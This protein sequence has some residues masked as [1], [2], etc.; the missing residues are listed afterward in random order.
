MEARLHV[1][2]WGTPNGEEYWSTVTLSEID[3][4]TPIEVRLANTIDR[5]STVSMVSIL[6]VR[7]CPRMSP[8][9]EASLRM[10]S[11]RS[12]AGHS[13]MVSPTILGLPAEYSKN[14]SQ[15]FVPPPPRAR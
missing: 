8:A 1:G 11:G 14:T 2:I 15:G 9:A 7:V 13:S 5:P 3:V 12:D 6:S 4:Q 10:T